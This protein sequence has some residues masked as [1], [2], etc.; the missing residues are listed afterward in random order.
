M[1][2]E[3][4]TLQGKITEQR[5]D[6]AILNPVYNPFG[7]QL[8]PSTSRHI[9]TKYSRSTVIYHHNKSSSGLSTLSHDRDTS[10]PSISLSMSSTT[11][12]QVGLNPGRLNAKQ[13]ISSQPSPHSFFSDNTKQ[14]LFSRTN[15]ETQ[16]NG[17][18]P[19]PE[20]T[21]DDESST[22]HK[23]PSF[24]PISPPPQKSPPKKS[25]FGHPPSTNIPQRTRSS[26]KTDDA[27]TKYPALPKRP[28]PS[29]PNQ[30]GLKKPPKLPPRRKTAPQQPPN[31]PP[32]N[33]SPL[34]VAKI[35]RR[36]NTYN[37]NGS[38]ID[39]NNLNGN[40]NQTSSK[41]FRQRPLPKPNRAPPELDD[42]KKKSL[43]F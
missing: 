28:V 22:E 31:K 8:K 15:R 5:I 4:L 3:L 29:T 2:H 20:M 23:S 9:K 25:P 34:D 13:L 10:I 17:G 6:P 11:H 35:V 30:N 26:A 16:H 41:Q 37:G 14:K 38:E 39:I 33:K 32:P 1:P 27:H 36:C 42:A 43:V 19:R 12:S 18:L 21:S 24:G 40:D 7:E